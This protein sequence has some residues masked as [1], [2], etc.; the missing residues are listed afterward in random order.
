MSEAISIGT[1][2]DSR[3][4]E[5]GA[6]VFERI[7][8][9]GTLVQRKI[10]GDRAGEL[11]VHRFLGSRAVTAQEIVSTLSDRTGAACAGRRIVVAQDTTEINFRGRDRRR[12]GLGRGGD[13]VGLGFF[14]H[15]VVAIDVEEEAVLGLLDA[16]IWTRAADNDGRACRQRRQRPLE[17]KESK[18]WLE[19]AERVAERAPSA[20]QRILVGDRESDLYPLFVR[21]PESVELVVRATQNRALEDGGYLFEQPAAWT[22]LASDTVR[23]APR[24]PGDPGRC[25]TVSLRAGRVCL[26]RQRN[27]ADPRDP[28]SVELTLVE[29]KEDEPPPGVTPLH[30]RLLTTL[31]AADAAA[32]REI[33][34][35]Y[36]LRWRIE[37]TFR[38]LKSDGLGLEEVQAQSA[39]RLFKLAAV[40]I[41]AAVRTIQLVDARDGG[42]RPASDVAD[43]KM[44][45]AAQV[46]LPTLEG[47]TARQRNPHPPHSLAWLAWIIAR[48][49]GWNCYY[50]PPGPKTMRAGWDRFAAIAAGYHLGLDHDQPRHH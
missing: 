46:L 4:A 10:G 32:A 27:R 41:G 7:V 8:S 5:R 17:D 25:A 44:V 21:R 19:A 13:G 34:Q 23:V 6:W 16:A 9:M 22:V 39:G 31:P 43:A 35:L 12:R 30:W 47:K 18:R 28:K 14:I 20:A 48:L 37:Q 45:Q 1:F 38:A 33:V 26:K 40:G 11:A 42:N 15:G 2:G 24:R 29:A 49:G 36:R 3:R 50:K